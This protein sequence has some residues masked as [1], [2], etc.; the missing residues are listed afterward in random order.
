[1]PPNR[2]SSD[3]DSIISNS[4][5]ETV[6]IRTCST[7]PTYITRGQKPLPDIPGSPAF[8]CPPPP[9]YSQLPQPPIHTQSPP[10]QPVNDY[11]NHDI[12]TPPLL[13]SRPEAPM[14]PP[15]IE[16]RRESPSGTVAL[17]LIQ[18]RTPK[19]CPR[20]GRSSR[21]HSHPQCFLRRRTLILLSIFSFLLSFAAVTLFCVML[22]EQRENVDATFQEG[23]Y[24]A[25]LKCI[26]L[27]QRPN[28]AD[29]LFKHLYNK[30]ENGELICCA[31][32]SRGFS[33]LLQLMTRRLQNSSIP[34]LLSTDH[35]K[36]T[37]VSAHVTFKE[38]AAES[39]GLDLNK[40]YLLKLNEISGGDISGKT[41]ARQVTLS[42]DSIEILHTGWYYVYSSVYFRPASEKPCKEFKYK[43]WGNYIIRMSPQ[44]PANSGCLV[45]TAHTC[46][47][48]CTDDHHS[49]FTGGVFYFLKGDHIYVESSGGGIIRYEDTASFFGLYMLG[50]NKPGDQMTTI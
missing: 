35:Y 46:C 5:A 26:V 16:P 10:P 25:C 49:T 6:S 44:S 39:K 15:A 2:S 18:R 13:P 34:E 23:D 42:A 43:T 3:R 19:S 33:A 17:P 47:D 38:T 12:Q 50:T 20:S 28:D 32:T 40:T 1:M 41:H 7:N 8:S 48:K 27:K 21:H 11:R 9:I 24:E 30:V 36:F 31:R 29:P 14:P 37:P 4:S 22:I 45:K